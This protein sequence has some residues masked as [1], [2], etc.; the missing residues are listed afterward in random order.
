MEVQKIAPVA[1][2]LL[3]SARGRGKRFLRTRSF[4]SYTPSS[5][6]PNVPRVV[7]LVMSSDK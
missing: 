2:S 6:E 7:I 3:D 4:K 1:K 5:C